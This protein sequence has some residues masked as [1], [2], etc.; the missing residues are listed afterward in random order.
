VIRWDEDKDAWLV[1][2]RGVSFQEIT[3]IILQGGYLDIFEHPGRPDQYI[4]ILRL[5]DYVWVVPFTIDDEEMIFLKTAF[6]SRKFNKRY[7]GIHER[8]QT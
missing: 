7:G 3:D 2:E 8:K 4:F 6:P 1:H 5:H